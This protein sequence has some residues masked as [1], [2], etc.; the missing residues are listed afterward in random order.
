LVPLPLNDL[1]FGIGEV[2]EVGD[3]AVNFG[4]VGG[5]GLPLDGDALLDEGFDAGFVCG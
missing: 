4:F 5:D 2:V 1:P 3:D